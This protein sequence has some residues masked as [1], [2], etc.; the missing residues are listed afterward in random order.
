M[1]KKDN[2][3]LSLTI[4]PETQEYLRET[5]PDALDLQHCVRH[6]ISDSRLL[7]ATLAHISQADGGITHETEN[8]EDT[9]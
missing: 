2:I 7:R 6:A 9:P 8:P 3:K 4:T 1:D 5:Y